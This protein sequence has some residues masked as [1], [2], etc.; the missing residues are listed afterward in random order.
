VVNG[1]VDVVVDV[2]VFVDVIVK[3]IELTVEVWMLPI[4]EAARS[5]TENEAMMGMTKPALSTIFLRI[6]RREGSTDANT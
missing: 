1:V 6:A 2:I 4:P 5:D 3:E